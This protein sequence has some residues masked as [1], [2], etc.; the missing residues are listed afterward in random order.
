MNDIILWRA[1]DSVFVELHELPVGPFLQIIKVPL[2]SSTAVQ[3]I[4]CSPIMWCHTQTCW[5]E[6]A[7]QMVTQVS[8]RGW[9]ILTSV[10][11]LSTHW[12][13]VI[14]WIMKHHPQSLLV[15]LV[16]HP[17]CSPSTQSH[18]SQ[19][20]YKGTMGDRSFAT[21][22]SERNLLLKSTEI[23][24]QSDSNWKRQ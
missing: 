4:S 18:S 1:Q 22:Q 20:G 8:D 23:Y 24:I 3:Y 9:I 21:T 7:P 10:F 11:I 2:S 17:F 15:Q 14:L 16:F 13:L 5:D 6:P 19:F 12:L